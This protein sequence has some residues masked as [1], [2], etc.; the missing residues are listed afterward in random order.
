MSLTLTSLCAISRA[1]GSIRLSDTLLREKL[2]ELKIPLRLIPGVPS[3]PPRNRTRSG[4]TLDS[5]RIT[6][7]PIA[8][9]H[10]VACGMAKIHPKSATL[11]PSNGSGIDVFRSDTVPHRNYLDRAVAKARSESECRGRAL[12]PADLDVQTIPPRRSS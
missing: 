8:P 2:I 7:A 5:T 10:A 12:Q 4:A 9:S 6:S 3:V 11:I 1:L